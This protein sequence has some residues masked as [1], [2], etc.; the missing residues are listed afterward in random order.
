MGSCT[1][2]LTVDS[3]S[4][5]SKHCSL[6]YIGCSDVT[7]SVIMI[8]SPFCGYNTT[9]SV[10]LNGK[11]LLCYSN[12]IESASLR[13]C[14]YDPWLTNKAYLSAVTVTNFSQSYTYKMVAK[15]NWH[16]YRI[17]NKITSLSSYVLPGLSK[18]SA[19]SYAEPAKCDIWQIISKALGLLPANRKISA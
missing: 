2:V 17:L 18:Y 5:W 14:P 15:V 1:W 3:S 8:R 6:V 10:E 11:D 9:L 12:K 19:L 16:R 13:K 7:E 4:A